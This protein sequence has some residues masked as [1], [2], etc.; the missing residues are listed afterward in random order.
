MRLWRRVGVDSLRPEKQE[1]GR[2]RQVVIPSPPVGWALAI[3]T[4]EVRDIGM[5]KSRG[6]TRTCPW[7][8]TTRFWSINAGPLSGFQVTAGRQRERERDRWL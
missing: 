8:D 7:W 5:R 1:R 6:A 3:R 4:G 2:G